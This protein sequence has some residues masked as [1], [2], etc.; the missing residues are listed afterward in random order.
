MFD[1]IDVDGD[2]AITADE[3]LDV[4]LN[5]DSGVKM[6]AKDVRVLIKFADEDGD[7]FIDR[8]EWGRMIKKMQSA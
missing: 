7:G 4:F 1:Q 8:Y 3:L 6:S 5:G 2:G